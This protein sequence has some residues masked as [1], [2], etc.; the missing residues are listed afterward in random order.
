MRHHGTARAPERATAPER[1]WRRAGERARQAAQA[2]RWHAGQL[3]PAEFGASSMTLAS[4]FFL[5]LFADIS[6]PAPAHRWCTV[7]WTLMC[8]AGLA[9]LAVARWRGH[10]TPGREL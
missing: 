6:M 9:W 8:V 4:A 5:A 1:A 10:G 3:S 7:E 2:A